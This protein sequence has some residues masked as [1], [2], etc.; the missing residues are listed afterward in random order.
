MST[1][2][3]SQKFYLKHN[4]DIGL[5]WF[6]AFFLAIKIKVNQHRWSDYKGV[7]K[8]RVAPARAVRPVGDALKAPAAERGEH[9]P[10]AATG[11]LAGRPVPSRPRPCTLDC[12]VATRR[13]CRIRLRRGRGRPRSQS[14]ASAPGCAGS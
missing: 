8:S 5:K 2:L 1:V 14:A 12:S 3:H 7:G 10:S 6:Q 4:F 9:R 13:V 11:V